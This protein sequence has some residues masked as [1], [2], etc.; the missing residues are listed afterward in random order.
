M[1]LMTRVKRLENLSGI[2]KRPLPNLI[3]NFAN[4]GDKPDR[5][6]KVIPLVSQQWLDSDMNPIGEPE[7]IV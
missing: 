3:I 6:L 1:S 4:P 2:N 5:Y 7:P